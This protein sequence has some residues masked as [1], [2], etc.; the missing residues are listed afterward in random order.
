M[1]LA[2]LRR[3]APAKS[4]EELLQLI[5]H[6]QVCRA[7]DLQSF[8]AAELAAGTVTTTTGEGVMTEIIYRDSDDIK[9]RYS[10]R[11]AERDAIEA[12]Q[13]NMRWWNLCALSAARRHAARVWLD[14]ISRESAAKEL[15]DDINAAELFAAH[16]AFFA[17]CCAQSR[18]R[19]ARPL[20]KC[21]ASNAPNVLSVSEHLPRH[22][23]SQ[24]VKAN[25]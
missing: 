13:R 2:T 8:C 19:H 4:R 5:A 7:L 12:Q 20:A 21:R 24:Q 14:R 6:K 18:R 3:T 25:T 10:L 23:A 22:A 15:R 11:L 16:Q 17:A 1:T 9:R